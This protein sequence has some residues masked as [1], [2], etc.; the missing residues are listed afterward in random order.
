VQQQEGTD[1]RTQITRYWS[2]PIRTD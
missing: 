1:K 2:D